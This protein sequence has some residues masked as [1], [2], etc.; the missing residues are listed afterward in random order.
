MGTRRLLPGELLRSLEPAYAPRLRIV[1][2]LLHR[3]DELLARG[4][5]V[6]RRRVDDDLGERGRV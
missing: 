1:E 2:D 4:F 6:D 3:V 5:I